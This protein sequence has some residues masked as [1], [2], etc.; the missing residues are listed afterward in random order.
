M[1]ADMRFCCLCGQSGSLTGEHKVKASALRAEFGTSPMVIGHFGDPSSYRDARGP[2]SKQFHFE[3][4]LCDRC[5]NERTQPADQAFDRLNARAK[6]LMDA[7]KDP[8]NAFAA[9]AFGVET[10]DYINVFRYFSKLLCCHIA[11]SGG[12]VPPQLAA[13]AMG[14][15]AINP[16]RLSIDADWTYRQVEAALGAHHYAAHG[17]LVV[18]GRRKDGVPTGFHSTLTV[19]PIRYIFHARLNWF[20]RMWM[21]LADRQFY[22]W[23]VSRVRDRSGSELSDAELLRLGLVSEEHL[24]RSNP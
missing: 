18:Y 20:G 4:R 5:N 8:A 3:A 11:D 15:N 7:G 16:I 21:R 10:A 12:R 19:G 6:A 9:E 24:E 23:C 1:K 17:G 13:F 14:R 2:K 22:D